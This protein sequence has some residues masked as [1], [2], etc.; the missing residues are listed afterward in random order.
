MTN[1]VRVV[2]IEGNDEAEK[3]ADW[4]NQLKEL[5][6]GQNLQQIEAENIFVPFREAIIKKKSQNCGPFPYGVGGSTPFHSFWGC[7]P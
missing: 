4:H 3:V 7:F 2:S 6:E 1:E 5:I